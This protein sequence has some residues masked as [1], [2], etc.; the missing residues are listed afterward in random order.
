MGRLSLLLA[1]EEAVEPLELC[2]R[3]M[4]VSMASL[5]YRGSLGLGR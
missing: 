1:V 2:N 3:V 5:R 4:N